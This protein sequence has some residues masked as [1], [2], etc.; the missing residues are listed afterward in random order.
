MSQAL[1]AHRECKLVKCSQR[2]K[3]ES[4]YLTKRTDMPKVFWFDLVDLDLS[5]RLVYEV[6]SELLPNLL[7][8]LCLILSLH[9]SPTFFK[10][11]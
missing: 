1:D 6:D 10:R 9:S 8:C 5:E 7:N 4:E 2:L 11:V 3:R